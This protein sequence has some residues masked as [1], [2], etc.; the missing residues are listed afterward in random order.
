MN[1]PTNP[2][3]V[4]VVLAWPDEAWRFSCSLPQ[5]SCVADALALVPW[6]KEA[7]EQGLNL[8]QAVVGIWGMRKERQTLL[9]DGDRVEIY[10]PMRRNPQKERVAKVAATD[11]RVNKA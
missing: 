10:R 7:A 2:L 8:E 3:R 11:A 6:A 1:N 9:R 5:G 4:T